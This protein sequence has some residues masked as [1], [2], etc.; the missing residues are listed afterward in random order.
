MEMENVVRIWKVRVH[1]HGARL[2]NNVTPPQGVRSELRVSVRRNETKGTSEMFNFERRKSFGK[3]IGDHVVRWAIEESHFAF[4][5]QPANKVVADIDM[6]GS[7][8][9]LRVLG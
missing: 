5:A 1:H 3:R 9:K 4:L 7:S 2:A 6:F 8:V